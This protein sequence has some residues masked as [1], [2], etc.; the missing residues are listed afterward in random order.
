[1]MTQA[2]GEIDKFAVGERVQRVDRPVGRLVVADVNYDLDLV[3][4]I[5]VDLLDFDLAFVVRADDRILDRL[6]GR[7]ER[8]FGDRQRPFVDLVDPGA[9]FDRSV[10]AVVGPGSRGHRGRTGIENPA[11]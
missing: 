8:N 9:H 6:G 3:G 10:P 11:A 1:M 4:R 7:A 2:F 5:V